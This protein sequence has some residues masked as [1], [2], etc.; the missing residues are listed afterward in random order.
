MNAT[1][2]PSIR[3]TT[4]DAIPKIAIIIGSIRNKSAGEKAARWLFG[5]AKARTD[6]AFEL[7]DLKDWP[8]PLYAYPKNPNEM[9]ADYPDELARRWAETVNRFDGFIMVTPEY[10]HGYPPSLKNALDY[11][12]AGWNRKPVAFVSYGGPAGGVR[13]VQQL[14][15][16]AVDLQMAPIRAEVNIQM[17]GRAF[18]EKGT[19]VLNPEIYA[20][21][22][23]ALFGQ[24]AWWTEV[25]R[26]GRKNRPLPGSKK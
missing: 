1:A 7:V 2:E 25:L 11:V 5:L 18:D 24:L 14:R 17:I 8:L 13:A 10:N 3:G 6:L 22:A 15:T 12:Y 19:L 16:V 4:M 26:D 23:Q 9:E 21:G 20:K